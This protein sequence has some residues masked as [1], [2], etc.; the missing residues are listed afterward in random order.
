MRF[1]KRLVAV[2][3]F[4]TAGWAA[5]PRLAQAA[6]LDTTAD[7]VFG[8]TD[9]MHNAPN[10][11]GA[12]SASGLYIPEGTALDGQGNLYVADLA[13]NRVL[14]YNA[15]LSSTIAAS[16][17]FGQGGSLTTATLNKG[18]ISADSLAG[19]ESVALDAQGNL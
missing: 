12:P 7:R 14:E 15:P 8:Q 13:N 11:G 4:L 2:I 3:L 6:N 17:V 18:G 10:Q 5:P 19:P 9:F 1:I 16:N